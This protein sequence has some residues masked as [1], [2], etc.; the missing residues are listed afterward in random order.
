MCTVDIGYA[1]DSTSVLDVES[2]TDV[3]CESIGVL[4]TLRV[5]WIKIFAHQVGAIVVVGVTFPVCIW[6]IQRYVDFVHV[7][8]GVALSVR[9]I[10]V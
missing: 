6:S 9:I 1:T 5:G 4:V 7:R 2:R 3:M 10:S 8:A